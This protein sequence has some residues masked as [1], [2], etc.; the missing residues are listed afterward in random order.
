MKEKNTLIF[1]FFLL[2]ILIISIYVNK[3]Y[4]G[5]STTPGATTPPGSTMSGTTPGATT[6]P[7]STMSGT[8]PGATMS[9]TTPGTTM[10]GTTPRTTNPPG[11]TMSGT[12]RTTLSIATKRP[13]TTKIPVIVDE[14]LY[15]RSV[16][17]AK[18]YLNSLL[19]GY[20][21]TEV[22]TGGEDTLDEIIYEQN[23]KFC[24]QYN[25][26]IP[27]ITGTNTDGSYIYGS[28]TNYCSMNGYP[29]ATLYNSA[30]NM[31]S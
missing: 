13:S 28:C 23:N 9:G 4:E 18:T 3:T 12:P 26:R 19:S 17:K 16:I 25:N 2:F 5:F 1:A 7:G 8:T 14:S 20:F 27:S 10:S 6:P 29:R 30:T 15:N 24:A 21:P 11:S 22:S 31:C